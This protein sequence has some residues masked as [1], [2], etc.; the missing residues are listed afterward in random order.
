M[1]R[2]T[3]ITILAVLAAIG[4]VLGILAGLLL[5]TVGAVVSAT[6]AL[7]GLVVIIGLFA[8]VIGVLD[9]VLAYGFWG[10]KPW[11]WSLGIGLQFAGIVLSIIQYINNNSN[12]VGTI[13][14]IAIS[15]VILYYLY[16]PS[17]KAAFGR[18]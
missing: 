5:L 14:S 10:L 18:S 4:G 15:A 3:G 12:L 8:L 7:G 17:V 16:Q 11:A 13:I 9:L 6:Y 1:Q 2:P